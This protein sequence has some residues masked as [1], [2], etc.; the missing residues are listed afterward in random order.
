MAS[1]IIGQQPSSTADKGI[2]YIRGTKILRPHA[3]FYQATFIG[4]PIT[5]PYPITTT[6]KPLGTISFSFRC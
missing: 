5:E 1:Q 2:G 6:V 3:I 4:V